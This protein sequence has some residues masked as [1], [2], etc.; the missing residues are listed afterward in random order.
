MSYD[1]EPSSLFYGWFSVHHLTYP[2][3]QKK[4]SLC[5]LLCVCICDALL[6]LGIIQSVHKIGSM[7]GGLSAVVG[8][9]TQ[10]LFCPVEA[11]HMPWQPQPLLGG[12]TCFK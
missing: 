2:S 6:I 3:S 7:V 1:F 8:S 11:L 5:G 9:C 12:N 10:I 4:G